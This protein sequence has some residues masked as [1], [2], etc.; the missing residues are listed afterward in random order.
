MPGRLVGVKL[1]SANALE[2]FNGSFKW[3]TEAGAIFPNEDTITHL[4]G[5]VLRKRNAEGAVQR[6]LYDAGNHSHIER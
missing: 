1:H 2:I 4:I 6:P 5:A 3:D